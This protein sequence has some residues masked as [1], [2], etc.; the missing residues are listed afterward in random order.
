M[1]NNF[2]TT[3]KPSVSWHSLS[4]SDALQKLGSDENAGL[5]ESGAKKAAESGVNVISE[6]KRKPIFLRIVE[7]LTEPM[8]LILFAALVITVAVNV[9][10][11]VRGGAF[12]FVEVAGILAAIVVSVTIS[13]VMEGK[14][15][16]AFEALKKEAKAVKVKIVRGGKVMLLAS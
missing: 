9:F 14:S 12:D 5:S 3:V 7:E 2:K 16:K 10:A 15:S 11:A 13:L 6:K 4:V 8:M 1:K